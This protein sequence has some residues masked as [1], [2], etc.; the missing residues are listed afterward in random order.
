MP[1]QRLRA[2]LG[3][4]ASRLRHDRTRTLLAVLGV[5]LAVISTTLLG[6]LGIGVVDTG[7]QKFDAADRDLWISGGPTRISP[8]SLGGFEGGIVDAHAVSQDL[9]QR[10]TIKT[11]APL[12]FQTVYV[13]TSPDSL[14]TVA[15]VGVTGDGGF[16]IAS[17]KGF[18]RDTGFYNNG[19]YNGTPNQN[20]VLGTQLQSQVEAGVGDQ[21]HIGGTIIDARQTTYNVTGTTPTFSKFLGTS[22]VVVPLAELQAMTGKSYTDQ[23]SLITVDVADNAD[24]TAVANRLESEYPQYTIRTNSEQLQAVVGER[25]LVVAAGGVLVALAVLAGIALTVNLLALLVF[26]EQD[27]LAALRAVGVSRSV[28]VGL[29]ATQGLCY[30]ILGAITGVLITYPAAAILNRIA[31][32]LVGFEGLVQITPRVLAAGAIIAII[33]GLS[34]AIVAGWRAANVS[35]LAMLNR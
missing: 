35:P 8:G 12:L 33:A 20:L 19:A 23:A 30:G 9:G 16:N 32:K 4:A 13:G 1:G 7:Q 29:V 11:A 25:I 14:E 3:L 27:A 17:G 28:V 22:T 24:V 2:V 18:G 26:Q 6:S 15:A 21:L 10:E 5:T 34:S 31:R